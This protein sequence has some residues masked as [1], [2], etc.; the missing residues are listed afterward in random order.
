[1]DVRSCHGAARAPRDSCPEVP[2]RFVPDLVVRGMAI[3]DPSVRSIVGQ[4]GRKVEMSSEKAKSMLGW[5]SRSI[6][7]TI[8]DCAR[9]MLDGG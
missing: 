5:S 8:V 1:M 9:S 2:K 4:L 6:E 7:E 3:F